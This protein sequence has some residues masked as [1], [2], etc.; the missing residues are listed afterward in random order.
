MSKRPIYIKKG[1]K[2]PPDFIHYEVG[3]VE[4]FYFETLLKAD[5]Y[6][7]TLLLLALHKFIGTYYMCAQLNCEDRENMMKQRLESVISQFTVIRLH[8]VQ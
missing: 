1:N 5:T 2:L 7:I 8:G 6:E 3:S 4:A